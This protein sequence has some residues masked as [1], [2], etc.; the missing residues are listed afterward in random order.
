MSIDLKN[1]LDR[2]ESRRQ[3]LMSLKPVPAQKEFILNMHK[4]FFFLL[5]VFEITDFNQR[6]KNI[7]FKPV[8]YSCIL[9]FSKVQVEEKAFRVSRLLKGQH[10]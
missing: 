3:N 1:R 2:S 6:H 10:M 8:N 4:T 7:S 9:K 5:Q